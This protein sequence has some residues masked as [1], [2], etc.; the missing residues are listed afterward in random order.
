ME[1]PEVER[2]IGV[3]EDAR[4]EFKRGMADL[5]SVGRTLCAFA[6]GVGGLLV[7][8]VADDGAVV[9]VDADPDDVQ[10]RLTS[11]LHTG[12]GKPVT[13]QCGRRDT[14]GGWVHWVAVHRHQRAWGAVVSID[15]EGRLR[16][17]DDRLDTGAAREY[18]RAARRLL[19]D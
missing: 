10:E 13:A 8:G 5:R 12:C 6:N 14:G 9:G 2:R 16:D 7:L 11:L 4:T 15:A 17:G 1:W 3:G 19:V 18:L